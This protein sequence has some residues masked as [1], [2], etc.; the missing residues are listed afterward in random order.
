MLLTRARPEASSLGLPIDYLSA[1]SKTASVGTPSLA[2]I[3]NA[4]GL[5]PVLTPPCVTAAWTL[6]TSATATDNDVR[7]QLI[8]YAWDRAATNKTT[9]KFPDDYN[10]DTGDRPSSGGGVAGCVSITPLSPLACRAQ[11][12]DTLAAQRLVLYSR[13]WR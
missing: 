9:G 5:P 2:N 6:L 13:T 7:D 11:L 4:T 8:Q 3:A 12:T 10:A 1:L